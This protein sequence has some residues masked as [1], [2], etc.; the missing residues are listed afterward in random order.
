MGELFQPRGLVKING[1]VVPGLIWF[2]TDA[3]EFSSPDTF[4]VQLAMGDMPQARRFSWYAAQA[5]M[6]VELFAGFPSDPDDFSAE[7]LDS[8]F[9]GKADDVEFDEAQ[10][11]VELVGR[12]LT[13]AFVDNKTSEKY[14]NQ[15]ASQVAEALAAKYGLAAEVQ[16]TTQRVGVY[17]AAEHVDLKSDRTEWDLLTWLA[18]QEGFRVYVKGKT[19]HF[20]APPSTSAAKPFVF[21]KKKATDD[22]PAAWNGQDV[23]FHRSL[24]VAKDIAVTVTSWNAKQKR[25]FTVKATRSKKGSGAN[26]QKYAYRIANLTLEQAQQRANKLLAEISQHEMKLHVEGPA[27]T[28]LA[29]DSVIRVKGTG[30]GFD[31][32][33]FP[34]SIA[35]RLDNSGGFQW[36]VDAKNHSPESEPNL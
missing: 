1:S 12:D 32:I 31:Q 24:T 7:E 2:E 15:T 22:G 27:D 5:D 4:R 28:A 6:E 16:D 35:R 33:Y 17:Y 34:Q 26:V 19:L 25:A 21:E 18:R 3:N 30:T 29:I 36:E 9:F 13:A 8:L 11:T 23:R 20:A 14:V 10:Q